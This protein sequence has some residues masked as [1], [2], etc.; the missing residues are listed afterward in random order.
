M[1]ASYKVS[2]IYMDGGSLVDIMYENCFNKLLEQV[3][4]GISSPTTLLI[5]FLCER[6][7]PGGVVNLKL[8]VGTHPLRQFN[9]LEAQ[10][11]GVNNQISGR[12]P[13]GAG[14]TTVKSDY[15]CKDVSIAAM[16][17]ESN[18]REIM[19]EPIPGGT[20][21]EQK[22]II[23]PEYPNQRITIKAILDMKPPKNSTEIQSLNGKLA[24]LSRFLS[25]ASEK[26]IPFFKA[27]VECNKNKIFKWTDEYEATFQDLKIFLTELPNLTTLISGETLTMYL[28]A[29]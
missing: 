13:T 24:A 17:E 6:S 18:L 26:Q 3:S 4:L 20:P 19:W 8:K 9:P 22:L 12:F 15:P 29:S 27:L 16:M 5:G 25:R 14:V 7:Y 28:A 21:N 10:H 1:I 2:R 23:N 11:E